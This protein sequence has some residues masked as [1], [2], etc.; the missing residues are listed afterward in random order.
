MIVLA[1][2]TA[3]LAAGCAPKAEKTVLKEG[4]PAYALAK[5]LAAVMPALDPGKT[6]IIVEAKNATI[7]AADVIQAIQDNLGKQ[8]ARFK[9]VDAGQMKNISVTAI[10]GATRT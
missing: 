7:T 10:C 8:T 2:V 9:G 1:A 5:D 3:M 6:T 4:T